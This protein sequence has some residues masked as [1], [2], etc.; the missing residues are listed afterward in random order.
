MPS[1]P[2]TPLADILGVFDKFLVRVEGG[3]V[4]A[5]VINGAEFLLLFIMFLFSSQDDLLSLRIFRYPA[6][7]LY[8]LKQ[9]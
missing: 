4:F 5:D 2:S 9:I 3:L 6:G 7:V 8:N 1:C